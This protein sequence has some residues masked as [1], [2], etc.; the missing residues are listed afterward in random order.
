[1]N[2]GEEVA[3][4]A[5][6]VVVEVPSDHVV[7]LE[8]HD[9]HVVAYHLLTTKSRSLLSLNCSHSLPLHHRYL[10]RQQK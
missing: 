3:I 5:E 1:M 2:V 10:P 4:A 8:D 6:D 9:V 7:V